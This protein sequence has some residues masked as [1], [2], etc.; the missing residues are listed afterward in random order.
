MYDVVVYLLDEKYRE[1]VSQIF[2]SPG[3]QLHLATKLP[4]VIEVCQND[5]LDLIIVWPGNFEIVSA[6]FQHLENHQLKHLPV[7]AV[8][9]KAEEFHY[10]AALPVA[11]VIS[12]PIPK[13]EFYRLIYQVL[14]PLR[15]ASGFTPIPASDGAFLDS[16]FIEAIRRIQ[17]AQADAL[18]TVTERGHIG[19]VYFHQGR[20][21]RASLRALEGMEALRKL[22]GLIRAE[23]KVH[24]TKVTEK[25]DLET[26]N[27]LI[28][29]ELKNQTTE[30]KKLIRLFSASHDRYRTNP[31]LENLEYSKNELSVQI[32]K[33][34]QESSDL[35]ELLAVMNQ[36][37]LEILRTVN[38]LLEKKALLTAKEMPSPVTQKEEKKSLSQIINSLGG[39]FK[40]S[41]KVS[42]EK[43]PLPEPVKT[44]IVES[45]LPAAK[46][47]DPGV[48]SEI[49]PESAI[50]IERF[51]RKTYS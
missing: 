4:T 17:V 48:S 15:K 18:L 31:E 16:S 19:R 24:F 2:S 32:L 30:Q 40:K 38:Q 26:E 3:Y 49:D 5:V 12:I 20:I 1:E 51:I 42:K 44:E 27:P 29:P 50:K 28:L 45:P 33:L 39:L 10:I 46:I 47:A 25:G 9:R 8:V 11:G 14:E 37:N 43:V 7:I 13:M 34:C 35:Y 41:K 6:L 23:V 36:D 22:A 21:V